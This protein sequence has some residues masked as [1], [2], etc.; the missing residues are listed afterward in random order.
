MSLILPRRKF[1]TGL[2]SLMAAPAI[3]R[4]SSLMPVKVVTQLTPE[5][6]YG[7]IFD[8]Y[9]NKIAAYSYKIGD[10]IK[11]D[12]LYGELQITSITPEM[13]YDKTT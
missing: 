7:K 8:N 3:V 12:V 6:I 9:I 11:F 13:F 5:E 1:I 10:M 2:V 4:A